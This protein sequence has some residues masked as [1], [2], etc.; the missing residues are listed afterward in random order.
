[1]NTIS[2]RCA[3]CCPAERRKHLEAARQLS[4]SVIHW[5]QTEAPNPATGGQGYPGLRPRG[6]VFGT[7]DGLAQYPYIRESR[8]LR[9]EFTVLEQHF[10]TDSPGNAR[11]PVKY[12]DSVGVSGYRIDIHRTAREGGGSI[13]EVAHGKHWLQQ[14]PVGRPSFRYGWRISC[15]RERI[16]G[17]PR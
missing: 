14:I 15:P 12:P 2:G 7:A 13:T 17:S 9:A 3:A 8:R 11:G 10:R 4:L 1:M 6:D 5:L 16:S